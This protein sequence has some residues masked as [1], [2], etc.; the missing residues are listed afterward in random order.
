MK[1][2]LPKNGPKPDEV[3]I[4]KSLD[5]VIGGDSLKGT[6]SCLF[7][8]QEITNICVEADATEGW[9]DILV[10]NNGRALIGADEDF[11][12]TRIHGTIQIVLSERP[13]RVKI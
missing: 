3:V 13:K 10:L 5:H 12:I 1:V 4:K 2:K 9:A 7:N 11:I 6:I 8:G